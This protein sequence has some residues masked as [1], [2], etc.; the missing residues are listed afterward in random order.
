MSRLPSVQNLIILNTSI[1]HVKHA[2]T[3]THTHMNK[4][5]CAKIKISVRSAYNHVG[6]FS[7]QDKFGFFNGLSIFIG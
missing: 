4:I 5:I 6:L 7:M 2:H 3:H 1:S